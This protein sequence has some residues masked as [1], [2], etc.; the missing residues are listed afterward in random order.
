MQVS[1]VRTD[2]AVFIIDDHAL[3]STTIEFTLKGRGI[4]AVRAQVLGKTQLQGQ[5]ATLQPGLVL[6]DLDLG[7]GVDGRPLDAA[8]LAGEFVVQGW[9][10]LILTGSTDRG[11]IAAAI[12]AGAAGWLSKAAPFPDLIYAILDA[13]AGRPVMD[14][15]ER[16][17]LLVEHRAAQ[18]QRRSSD[19]VLSRLT[20][21]EREV[22]AQLEAGKRATVIAEE[23]FVSISTVRSQIRSILSKLNVKSQLEAVALAR[24]LRKQR[25]V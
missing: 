20:S 10:V 19:Q 3:I 22:L 4:N 9:T 7:N 17:R 21:R 25:R 15:G 23:S 14:A 11:R 13:L 18:A 12:A 8:T 24:S 5:A 6:L 2:P 16:E 1:D